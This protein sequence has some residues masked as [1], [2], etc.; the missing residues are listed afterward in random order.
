[1]QTERRRHE[2]STD[3]RADGD[4]AGDPVHDKAGRGGKLPRR[5]GPQVQEGRPADGGLLQCAA[6]GKTAEFIEKYIRKGTKI[7]F[8]GR[9]Q[10]DEY[11]T[12]EGQKVQ[13]A[14]IVVEEIEFCEKK[15]PQAE[16]P[17]TDFQ[18]VD[19]M[20]GDELPFNF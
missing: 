1:M 20:D 12:K 9:L 3:D 6:F 8:S 15:D 11:T 16:K 14:T 13:R 4:R 10:N 19:N 18:P 2:Q 5:G 17:A 7:G